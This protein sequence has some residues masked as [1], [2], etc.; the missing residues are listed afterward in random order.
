MKHY[1]FMLPELFAR[2]PSG[3]PHHRLDIKG[4]YRAAPHGEVQ[5]RL[6]TRDVEL[7]GELRQV[8]FRNELRFHASKLGHI[9]TDL[10]VA[11]EASV[12]ES[13]SRLDCLLLHN[14]ETSF[15]TS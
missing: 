7:G 1:R 13:S 5:I 11:Q 15:A 10:V 8:H 14:L 3:F 4:L 2:E 9:P 12:V 6:Q